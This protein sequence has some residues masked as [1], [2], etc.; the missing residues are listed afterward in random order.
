[1]AD[2]T[3]KQH[4]TWPPLEATLSDA[5]G[6]INLTTATTIRLIIKASAGITPYLV[7]TCTIVNAITGKVK[8]T[9]ATGNLDTAGTYQGEF[10]ITWSDSSIETVPNAGYFS[11]E[12][13]PDLG[14]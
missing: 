11:F 3:I 8:A 10:E 2:Y 6:P 12:I 9:W 14:P 1:M 7:K 5:D 4:D 13:Q